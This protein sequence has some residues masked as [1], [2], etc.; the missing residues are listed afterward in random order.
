MYS[1]AIYWYTMHRGSNLNKYQVNVII[2]GRTDGKWQEEES[3]ALDRC[4]T[5]KTSS[6]LIKRDSDSGDQRE[7]RTVH[8]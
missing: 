7:Q 2:Q 5:K 4:G 3:T 1:I 8:S 6:S